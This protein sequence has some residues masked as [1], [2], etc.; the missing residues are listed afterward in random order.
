MQHWGKDNLNLK[1]LQLHRKTHLAIRDF[2]DYRD[3][4]TLNFA[5]DL[6]GKARK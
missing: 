5:P 1:G 3:L 6:C 4:R 2:I